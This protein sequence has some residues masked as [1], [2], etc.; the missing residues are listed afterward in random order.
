MD[1]TDTRVMGA[2]DGEVG[3]AGAIDLKGRFLVYPTQALPQLDSPSAFAYH[4]VSK[5]DPRAF[6]ALVCDPLVPVRT[7][8][9]E[10]LRGYN[11]GGMLKVADWGMV[12]WPNP[13]GAY[14]YVIIVER[15]VGTRVMPNLNEQ[16]A[17][18]H[19][20]DI[21]DGLLS[22]L[23]S[24][25]KEFSGRM[26]THRAIRPDNIFYADGGRRTMI[27]GECVSSPPAHDQPGIF[28]TIEAA[29]AHP[30]GRGNGSLANDLYSL[31]VTVIFLVL[32]RNPVK[33]LS[34]SRLM[35]NKIE[36]GTYAALV[37]SARVP[38]SLMEPL[39]GLLTDDPRERWTVQDLDMW[40]AGRRQSPKQPKLPQRA[41][42]PFIYQETE[43]FNTRALA[44]VL[45]EDPSQAAPI[46]RSKQLD[47]WLRRS[48]NDE[49]RA[50]AVQQAVVSGGGTA[51]R[52]TEDRMVARALIPLDPAAPLRYRGFGSLIDG[53]GPALA[54]SIDNREQRQIIAE[55][56]ASRLP[57]NWLAAQVK[58][59]SEDARAAQIL[60][61]LPSVIE[62]TAIGMGME[63]ALYELN[64]GEHCHS[65]M[66]DKDPVLDISYLIP[67]LDRI[68]KQENRP[69][70]PLDRHSVAFIAARAR[71]VGDEMI[72]ACS[73]PDVSGRN[74][75]FLKLLASVQE[76]T[77]AP[78]CPGLC[79]W[80]A[81]LL[82]PVV[83][84]Y[85][86]K[87]RREKVAERVRKAAADGLLLQLLAVVDDEAEQ[88][89]D[90]VGFT[91][92]SNEYGQIEAK[93]HAL[94]V[95]RPRRE[96]DARY[97]GEQIAA[98]IGGVLVSI[99]TAIA[100][101]VSFVK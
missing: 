6:Y 101:F 100:V 92:A 18:I 26:V 87:K 69:D 23:L 20:D 94:E 27:L 39:R 41:S 66:F 1:Q 77:N 62:N 64:P 22:P 98:A 84:R 86:L 9:L 63:R 59:R 10:M 52:A 78:A 3:D 47:A 25:L 73:Q 16:Q 90:S 97:F 82:Q 75:A 81:H 67:A 61:R 17:P 74:L 28:E 55:I 40:L 13:G 54:A 21:V 37:G 88:R 46:L 32:G 91:Q 7:D 50:E 93:L 76:Q 49:P 80:M 57:M 43:Y 4:A 44:M 51:G 11:Q 85:H 56:I 45:A 65:P 83:N 99:T 5:G 35:A 72:R 58:P 71:R 12:P 68:A 19:E 38:L 96:E 8:I 31:G 34:E 14:R 89:A 60:E 53:L 79:Q 30:T 36:F 2:L 15:P 24:T 42:R 70:V 95:N 33:E 29:M 48:L